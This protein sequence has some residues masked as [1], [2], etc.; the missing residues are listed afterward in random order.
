MAW[1]T[2][3][4]RHACQWVVQGEGLAALLRFMRLVNR[5]KPHLEMLRSIMTIL[6]NLLR[7][8]EAVVEIDSAA[9]A[10]FVP[11]LSDNLQFFRCASHLHT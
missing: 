4:S 7:H 3:Y 9:L 6:S 8:P 11:L 2:T 5:S 10:D 1:G